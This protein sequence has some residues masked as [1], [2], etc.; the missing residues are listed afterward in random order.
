MQTNNGDPF[1]DGGAG[2]RAAPVLCL[3]TLT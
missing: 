3:G 2:G 1:V